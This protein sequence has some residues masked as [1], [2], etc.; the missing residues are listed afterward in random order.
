ME[1]EKANTRLKKLRNSL[2]ISQTD[3][4]NR[5]GVT[6]YYVSA[7]ERGDKDITRKV[8]EKLIELFEVSADW[9]LAGTGTMSS[10]TDVLPI[11]ESLSYQSEKNSEKAPKKGQ[12]NSLKSSNTL[13]ETD[14]T[15]LANQ[16]GQARSE[17][18][19]LRSCWS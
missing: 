1:P 8:I 14:F 10:K 13:A 18:E 11:S 3:L 7:V 16:Y 6:P 5:L 12:N 9:L 17:L 2:G 15:S 4:A 19:G